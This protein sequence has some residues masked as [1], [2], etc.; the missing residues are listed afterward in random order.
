[1]KELRLPEK[2]QNGKTAI[3][4]QAHG[5]PMPG[6]YRINNDA[7]L[8]CVH[9][10]EDPSAWPAQTERI[11]MHLRLAWLMLAMS[12]AMAGEPIKES[13]VEAVVDAGG[14]DDQD[15][16]TQRAYAQK[17]RAWLLKECKGE[18]KA[19]VQLTPIKSLVAKLTATP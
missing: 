10:G 7:S 4:C 1:M 13:T 14:P 11:K 5:C 8:C 15:V 17:I 16:M 6:V 18:R 19:P 2:P 9:D 12:N 3:E